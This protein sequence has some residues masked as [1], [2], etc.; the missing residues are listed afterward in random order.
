MLQ[1]TGWAGWF[2]LQADGDQSTVLPKPCKFCQPWT[3]LTLLRVHLSYWLQ[4]QSCGA[5]CCETIVWIWGRVLNSQLFSPELEN[6]VGTAP[7]SAA[8]SYPVP[9]TVPTQCFL[10]SPNE[11]DWETSLGVRCALSQVF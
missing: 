5:R 4:N 11:W 2:F 9:H 3:C 8:C 1:Q 10:M 6:S 7:R